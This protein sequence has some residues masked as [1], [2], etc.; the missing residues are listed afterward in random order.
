MTFS[1]TLG[2]L[3]DRNNK[4]KEKKGVKLEV[5]EDGTCSLMEL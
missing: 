3:G 5:T 1:K 2:T 4:Q